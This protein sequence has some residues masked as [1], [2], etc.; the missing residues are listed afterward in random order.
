MSPVITLVVVLLSVLGVVVFLVS[1]SCVALID[2]VAYLT[3]ETALWTSL[4]ELIRSFGFFVCFSTADGKVSNLV[5][6]GASFWISF[7]V[8]INLAI[9]VH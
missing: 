2:P 6:L 9:D 7:S 4:S 8:A 3:T 1:S 5:T